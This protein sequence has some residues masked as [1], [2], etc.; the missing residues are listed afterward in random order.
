M[1]DSAT[2][3][4]P[5]Y[6]EKVQ[7]QLP[8]L[9]L[10]IHM[11]WTYLPPEACVRLRDGRLGT[12]ILEPVLTEFIRRAGRFEFKGQVRSFTENAIQNAVQTL[13]A[14]RATG[15]MQQNEQ[16]YE[17]LCLG[18]S[19]PQT[20][21]GDT[22]SFMVNFIDWRVAEN[23]T[24][25]CTAEF[26]VERIGQQKVYIPDIVL[27]INGIPLVVME[28]KRSAYLDTH[29][30]PIDIA[31]QDL[32]DYQAKEGIPQLFL[33][34]QLLLGLAR[35]KAE[36]GTTG[37]P[38]KFW[39]VWKESNLDQQIHEL[40]TRPMPETASQLLTG[41]FEDAADAFRTTLNQGRAVYEQDRLLYALCR[42]DRFLELIYK[43][44][45]FDNGEKK[46]ARYQQFFTVLD[47]LQRVRGTQ[48]AARS[49][50]NRDLAAWSGTRRAAENR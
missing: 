28:C 44:I 11:G 35:D 42:P 8:A 29:K 21:E 34:S 17:L 6:L 37:T 32:A 18:T 47:I 49:W 41:P 1:E 48:D 39:T 20:I 46:I 4:T 22:K 7:C 38:R 27:F 25:H 26:K 24:Y 36:Y 14:F 40:L 9:Q 23:N 10:L 19:V 31:I 33:Y 3:E 13:R 30:E 16:A 5:S 2:Y 15:A 45:V 43:F 50:E 12:T